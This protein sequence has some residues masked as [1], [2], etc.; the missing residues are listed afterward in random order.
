MVKSFLVNSKISSNI[1]IYI[2][3]KIA[4][5]LWDRDALNLVMENTNI[6]RN[7]FDD[8][9]PFYILLE[10]SGSNRNHD[11]EKLDNFLQLCM[12]EKLVLD[13]VLA[14]DYAQVALYLLQ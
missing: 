9:Y 2:I 13:G 3:I 12:D 6:L 1:N 8:V 7:P 11:A 10:T 14:Q 5:E 4:F